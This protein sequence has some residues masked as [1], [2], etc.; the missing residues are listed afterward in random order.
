MRPTVAV[1]AVMLVA[2]AGAYRGGNV[3]RSLG[4]ASA[5]DATTRVTRVLNQ[6]QYDIE[7]T[8]TSPQLLTIQ[9]RWKRRPPFTD[10]ALE[11]I[12][13]AETRVTVTGRF[14][15]ETAQGPLYAIDLELENRVQRMDAGDWVDNAATLQYRVYADSLVKTLQRERSHGVRAYQ[16]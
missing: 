5:Q 7:R 9:T 3:Q 15:L 14:R 10:E 4:N 2:C 16:P 1:A 12:S 13:A 8:E 6:F 11:G